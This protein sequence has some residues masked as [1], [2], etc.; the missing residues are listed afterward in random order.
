MRTLPNIK[1][2]LKQLY[3]VIR[4]K[5][6]PSITGGIYY[7]DIDIRWMVLPSSFGDLVVSI[8]SESAQKEY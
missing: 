5:C 6:I 4:T 3:D 2:Q 7:S 1:N 8:F